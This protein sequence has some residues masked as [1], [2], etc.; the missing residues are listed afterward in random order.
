[1]GIV[2][3]RISW[4]NVYDGM[5]FTEP[6]CVTMVLYLLV[7]YVSMHQ[8]WWIQ[9]GLNYYLQINTNPLSA[10]LLR[11]SLNLIP[12]S[13]PDH[14]TR[15]KLTYK[16]IIIHCLLEVS[17]GVP[18]VAQQKWIWLVSMRPQVQSLA[19][20]SGLRIQSCHELWCGSDLALLWQWCRPAGMDPIRPLAWEPPY[21]AGVALR[22]RQKNKKSVLH[23]K[24]PKILITCY[25]Q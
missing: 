12:R 15:S 24:G 3:L 2:V 21:A 13:K 22:D 20:L 9:R 5:T 19:S 17:S 4:A 8:F 23:Y 1:M 18:S 7:S 10:F 11:F 25:L 16:L 14:I 6:I